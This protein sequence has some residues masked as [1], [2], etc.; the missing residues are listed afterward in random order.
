MTLYSRFQIYFPH[1]DNI[2]SHRST[3]RY[4]RKPFASHYWDC[5]LKGRASGTPKS[6]DP[7]K[8][9]RKRMARERDLCDVKIKI[10]EYFPTA[11][12]LEDVAISEGMLPDMHSMFPL[13]GNSAFNVLSARSG[14]SLPENHPGA[15]GRRYFTIQRVNGTVAQGSGLGGGHQH[16]LEDSDRVKKNSV[17]RILLREDKERKKSVVCLSLLIFVEVH[18]WM[19]KTGVGLA[20]PQDLP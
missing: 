18:A 9:K 19:E 17:Q 14:S 4:K 7:N 10:T 6:D 8:K 3:Q 12:V 13:Q 1:I 15:N 20:S 2:Y 16:S 11:G 5:R